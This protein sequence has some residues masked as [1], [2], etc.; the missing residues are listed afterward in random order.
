[1]VFNALGVEEGRPS[2]QQ[3]KMEEPP[4]TLTTQG[5]QT[6]ELTIK[7]LPTSKAIKILGIFLVPDGNFSEQLK[8][9]KSKV[10]VLAI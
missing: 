10:D 4:L 6:K 5:D 1:M 7:C 2:L 3:N 9:L 8:L